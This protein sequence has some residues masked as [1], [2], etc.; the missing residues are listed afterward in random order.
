MLD[1]PPDSLLRAGLHWPDSPSLIFLT[2]TFMVHCARAS[3]R[4]PGMICMAAHGWIVN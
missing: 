2:I 4:A 1:M 3:T